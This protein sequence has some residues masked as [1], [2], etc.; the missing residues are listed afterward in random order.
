MADAARD[1]Y[2]AIGFSGAS[3]IKG[4]EDVN[5]KADETENSIKN[6]GETA[7]N[8]G[9]TFETQM[10]GLDKGFKLWETNA[11]KLSSTLEKKQKRVELLKDKTSLL[12]KEIDKTNVELKEAVQKYGENSEAAKKLEN[13]LL[14][15]KIKQADYNN[16]VKKLN[17]FDWEGFDKLGTK[18]TKIGGAMTA[19]ITTPLVGIGVAGTKTFIELED[20]FAGVEKTVDASDEEL[21]NLR[22]RLNELVTDGGIPVKVTEMYGIAEAAGQLGIKMK[23]IEGFSE[24]MAK[25]GTATNMTSEQAATDLAQ[26]ANIVQMPQENFNRLGSTIVALGNNLAT[27]ESEITSM[28]LR[29]SGAGKQIGLAESQILGFA[30]A[31]SS[32]GIEAEAGGSAFSKVMIG[33]QNSVMNMDSS[34]DIFA[35]VSGKTAEEF[36]QAFEKDAASALVDF[37][38]G[39]GLLQKE[40][41]NTNDILEELG[42][43]EIRV[44]DALR[45]AANSGD[46]FRTALNIGSKAWEENK[47]LTDEA[48]KK[49]EKTASQIEVFK[50]KVTLLSEKIG[51]DLQ[52]KFSGLLGIGTKIVD[53]LN[54]LD[55]GTRKAIVTV[56]MVVAAIGPLF[57]GLGMGIKAI[58][59]I[60]NTITELGQGMKMLKTA[61]SSGGKAI[62]FLTSPVGIAIMA[63]GTL[64]TIGYLLYKNWDKITAWFKEKFPDAFEKITGVIGGFKDFLSSNMDSF[65]GIFQGFTTFIDGVFSGDLSKAFG[66][67]KEVFAN[68]KTI[69]Q[70]FINSL[71]EQFPESFEYISERFERF[72]TVAI[73]IWGSIKQIFSGAT[74]FVK[75]IINGDFSQ[76]LNGLGNV[77]KGAFDLVKSVLNG[78]LTEIFGF[79]ENMLA[80][81]Q[82]EFPYLFNL[83]SGQLNLFKDTV[84]RTIGNIQQVFNGL[85]NFVVGIFT[86]DWSKAWQGVKDV[87]GGIFSTLGDLLKAPINTVINLVNTAI[88]GINESI[89]IKIPDWS[90]IF[91]GKEIGF[92][93]PTIPM[94]AKGTTYHIGGPAIVGEK[95]PEIVNLNK[96]D[97][98]T[99]TDK[100]N[101]FLAGLGYKNRPQ[102]NDSYSFKK[103][104]NNGAGNVS[105]SLMAKVEVNIEKIIVGGE[106]TASKAENLKGQIKE[107]FQEAW[108]D[109]WYQ[110]C[111]KFPSLTLN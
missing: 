107:I 58:K 85:I 66:G 38:E 61:F 88:K 81:L 86:I 19:G 93:I 106:I 34:L 5:K 25:L 39:L 29:L 92:N 52:K 105:N 72:K 53:W 73:D 80:P 24:V 63:I 100:T 43:S 22:K 70:P 79:F 77:F 20:A 11:G 45:R 101:K 83:F 55:D 108:E 89:K 3:A 14:D 21:I 74:E 41:F 37:T 35:A 82:E 94:L 32:V 50:N 46:V 16:E 48:A 69:A 49:Y 76:A 87:F 91:G 44:S 31:L 28:G 8:I 26:F 84:F 13:Q 23:N 65:K 51:S 62:G 71:K 10:A 99:P 47:A 75:G 40:G 104:D 17:S 30:G 96:G 57:L 110:L 97:T 27:T 103:A 56:G 64:I 6:I 42:F 18:F 60:K 109:A 7:K 78:A 1:L 4:L 68:L 111:L 12:E 59:G 95:G 2:V 36:M 67:I 90:P 102:S 33:M 98:V 15:L 54:N 9:A